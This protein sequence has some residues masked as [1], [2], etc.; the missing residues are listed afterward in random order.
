[1]CYPDKLLPVG[2]VVL[3]K[4]AEKGVMI[5]GFYVVSEQN[6]DDIFDYSAC[7]YPEG[8]VASDKNLLFNH[9]QIEKVLYFGFNGEEE[10]EFKQK[11]KEGLD[12]IID[13]EQKTEKKQ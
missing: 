12:R 13:E 1:M 6:K 10:K 11:L 4:N 2:S 7:L 5:N 9:D 3:L 8:M